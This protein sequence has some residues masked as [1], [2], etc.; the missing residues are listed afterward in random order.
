MSSTRVIWIDLETFAHATEEPEKVFKALSF[1]LPEGGEKLV[2][3]ETAQGHYRNIII[4]Y[5]AKLS[6]KKTIE[7]FLRM[8]SERMDDEDKK[9]LYHLFDMRFDDSG[10]LYLRFDKQEAFL[11]RLKLSESEDVIRVRIRFSAHP[12]SKELI[13]EIC[14]DLGLMIK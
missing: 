4:I 6:D 9:R 13:E 2:S 7:W 11:G 1:L 10:I 8:L 3:R 5:K 14:L 12:V